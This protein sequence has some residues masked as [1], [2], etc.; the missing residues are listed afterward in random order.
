MKRALL[1]F[2][3]A[4]VG[5]ATPDWAQAAQQCFPSRPETTSASRFEI[6]RMDGTAFDTAT[7]LT[8]KICAEGQKYSDGRC[9]GSA[10][11]SSWDNAMHTFGDKG[12]N[13]R[14]PNEDELN[15]IVERRCIYP[16]INLAV[17]PDTPSSPFWSG[18]SIPAGAW[19]VDFF[20]GNSSTF[21]R[22]AMYYV[23]LVRGAQWLDPS[24]PLEIRRLEDEKKQTLEDEK[25]RLADAVAQAEK[26]SYVTCKTKG[27]CDK[28]F[29]LTQTYIKSTASQKIQLV[30]DTII[31]TY[32]PTESGNISMRA[33]KTPAQASSAVIRL[34]VFC[35][36]DDSGIYDKPCMEKKLEIYNGFPAYINK[37]R[38]D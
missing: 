23:R 4:L 2:S 25:K 14:L 5:F 16:A 37:M 26:G 31:E 13:W 35:K 27:I 9:A 34:S 36:V 12:D 22:S 18:S 7:K 29:S 10:T 11:A 33:I 20:G 28:L 6:N 15:S 30:T 17:F 38:S 19:D 32:H 3:T 1:L 21:N 24:G 8:W